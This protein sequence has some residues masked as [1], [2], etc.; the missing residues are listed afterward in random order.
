[1]TR[2]DQ[3]WIYIYLFSY[4]FISSQIYDKFDDFDIDIVN[5]AFLEGDFR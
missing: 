4:G 2:K 1:M 5:F 3:F